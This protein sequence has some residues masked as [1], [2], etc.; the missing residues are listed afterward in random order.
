MYVP[1]SRKVD[2]DITV[3]G[4]EV[5]TAPNDFDKPL[6]LH[7]RDPT[8]TFE[9]IMDRYIAMFSIAHDLTITHPDCKVVW[10]SFYSDVNCMASLN[11]PH[12]GQGSF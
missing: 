3:C 9:I 1:E 7:I 6:E 4:N 8:S 12:I 5:L 10:Y 11:H 2:M